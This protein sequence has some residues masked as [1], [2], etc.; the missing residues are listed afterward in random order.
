MFSR[1]RGGGRG[2]TRAATTFH[3]AAYD[4]VVV[5]AG[6]AGCLLANRL[7]VCAR[8]AVAAPRPL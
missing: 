8:P 7:S 6:S 1:I 5:G 3:K 2:L 4:Y